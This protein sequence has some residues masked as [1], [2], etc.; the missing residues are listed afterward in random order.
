MQI[1]IRPLADIR[2]YPGNPRL[3]DDAVEAVAR[4][5]REFGFRQPIVVDAEGVIVC[6]HT[7][8]KAAERLSSDQSPTTAERPMVRRP[9]P[10]RQSQRKPGA[11]AAP[12]ARSRARSRH[13]RGLEGRS[14][15]G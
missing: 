13:P 2:P 1:E 10:A 7:R 3:N 11:A 14:P 12:A 4:S 6:G 8:F 15:A 9:P 5:I